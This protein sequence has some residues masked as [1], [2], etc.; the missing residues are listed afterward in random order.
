MVDDGFL[1]DKDVDLDELT[2]QWLRTSKHGTR[3]YVNG[4]VGEVLMLVGQQ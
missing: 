3:Y 1:G 4:S 2:V